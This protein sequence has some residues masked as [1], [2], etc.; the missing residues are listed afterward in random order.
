MVLL[1]FHLLELNHILKA[2]TVI[3][4]ETTAEANAGKG[5]A[6]SLAL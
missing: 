2:G 5:S 6:R 1:V 3:S 4:I